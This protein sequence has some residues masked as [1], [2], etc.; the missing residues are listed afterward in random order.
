MILFVWSVPFCWLNRVLPCNLAFAT[1]S[2]NTPLIRVQR[3]G[4]LVL[5]IIALMAAILYIERGTFMDVAF[6]TFELIRTQSLAPQV[7]RFG[8]GA[9]Q[10]FPLMAIWCKAPLW[11]VVF[12]YSVGVVLY[13][14]LLF[15]YIAFIRKDAAVALMLILYLCLATTHTFFWIQ[16]EFSQSIPFGFAC[17]AFIRGRSLSSITGIQ[18]I[19]GIS[20]LVTGVFFH[21]LQAPL[22][23]VFFF[24]LYLT[25]SNKPMMLWASLLV[26]LIWIIKQVFFANWYDNMATER[27][28]TWHQFGVTRGMH[29]MLENRGFYYWSLIVALVVAMVAGIYKKKWLLVV[30]LP[31]FTTTYFL[32][33][34][35]SHPEAE[36]FYLE[37]LMLAIPA[38]VAY[39]LVTIFW[40]N[41]PADFSFQQRVFVAFLVLFFIFRIV[42]VSTYYKK[43]IQVYSSLVS[44][45]REQKIMIPASHLPRPYILFA[46]PSAYEVWMHSTLQHGVTASVLFFDDT[47]KFNQNYSPSH[48]FR[49]VRNYP[50]DSLLA[51]YFVW[52]DS[53]SAYKIKK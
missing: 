30:F 8:S 16:S 12:M 7:Y 1:M 53:A 9:T 43:R 27:I 18:A 33:I 32:F 11:M 10:I 51:P 24:L 36:A 15:Y 47:T 44:H 39:V 38:V 37:N 14:C 52:T 6:Q 48:Q 25:E 21:P 2:S 49:G 28:S 22:F 29:Q 19:I 34:H 13:Q 41:T 26:V 31:L 5:F 40:T 45:Y 20:L 3:F 50:Y 46:W 4:T 42:H 17:I 35:W 23:L